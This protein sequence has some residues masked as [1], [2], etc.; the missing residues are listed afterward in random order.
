[1]D[2]TEQRT[3]ATSPPANDDDGAGTTSV[4]VSGSLTADDLVERRNVGP[5]LPPLPP[6]PKEG[7]DEATI[8]REL[9]GKYGSLLNLRAAA[10][11]AP[12][13]IAAAAAAAAD[14]DKLT[15]GEID[16]IYRKKKA[17]MDSIYSVK[18]VNEFINQFIADERLPKNQA[19]EFIEFL[20][21]QQIISR[22]DDYDV[23]IKDINNSSLLYFTIDHD[24]EP[25]DYNLNATNMK[26]LP[27]LEQLKSS[28][29]LSAGPDIQRRHS[30]RLAVKYDGGKKSRKPK[31]KQKTKTKKSRKPK[32]K[33]KRKTKANKR[34][35]RTRRR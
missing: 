10:A 26:Y 33:P 16:E 2:P 21:G 35:T 6:W 18:T 14:D 30:G 11:A 9:E 15:F 3:S 28:M 7:S 24:L 4:A 17:E 34:R 20:K 13:I 23:P 29:H 31:K 19:G 32:R 25:A 27:I 1:M 12:E 22:I 8:M 5:P